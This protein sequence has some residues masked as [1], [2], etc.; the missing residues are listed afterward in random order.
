MLNFSIANSILYT[1]LNDVNEG[2]T[3]ILKLINSNFRSHCVYTII[4]LF[5]Q[6][7]LPLAVTS[8][9]PKNPPLSYL[10]LEFTSELRGA[11]NE[12]KASFVKTAIETLNVLVYLEIQ[13]YQLS[14][15]HHHLPVSQGYS[16]C[17]VLILG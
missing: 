17:S 2:P 10:P 5:T 6:S 4:D 1:A 12:L 16:K 15:K 9:L 14:F 8:M 3:I 11:S 7:N 13:F